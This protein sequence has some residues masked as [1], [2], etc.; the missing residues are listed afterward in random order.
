MPPATPR[1]SWALAGLRRQTP[2][3]EAAGAASFGSRSA[4]T[5]ALAR[6][7]PSAGAPVVAVALPSEPAEEK[8]EAVAEPEAAASGLD[9]GVHPRCNPVRHCPVR[10]DART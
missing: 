6:E 7:G 5:L 10:T 1:R 9:V 3:W 4:A 8:A 2:C